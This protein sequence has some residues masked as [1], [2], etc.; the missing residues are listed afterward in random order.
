M[1]PVST[2]KI[3]P[4][5]RRRD[6]GLQEIKKTNTKREKEMER[7]AHIFIQ[8]EI[9]PSSFFGLSVSWS[10]GGRV[11][12]LDFLVQHSLTSTNFLIS[13]VHQSL[14]STN[15]LIIL[16][17]FFS[18]C[19]APHNCRQWGTFRV[20]NVKRWNLNPLK[21]KSNQPH[22]NSPQVLFILSYN[23]V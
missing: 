2:Q 8:N 11:Q 1:K 18:S 22:V 19:Y 16:T 9:S 14:S 7:S 12:I 6:G 3:H 20:W 10:T 17:R 5:R 4:F 21:K 15:F 23:S 13:L